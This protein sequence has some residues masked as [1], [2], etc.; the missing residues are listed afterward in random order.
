MSS[1]A[2]ETLAAASCFSSVAKA[3][4]PIP[5]AVE[6]KSCRRVE[7]A[8]RGSESCQRACVLVILG[9]GWCLAAVGLGC[10]GDV[11][12][13][14][15]IHDDHGGMTNTGSA[16]V[17]AYNGVS[18]RWEMDGKLTASDGVT[19]GGFGCSV[20]I[21]GDTAVVGAKGATGAS[22]DSGAVYVFERT[23]GVWSEGAKLYADLGQGGDG[24]ERRV[25]RHHRCGSPADR[26]G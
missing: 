3:S 22:L 26:C 15:S 6:P 7:R 5:P 17:F 14:G 10:S 23:G 16:Y 20:D 19:E 21:E 8:R 13:V 12:V 2:G 24:H 9:S 25:C 11:A 1:E 4:E 18:G